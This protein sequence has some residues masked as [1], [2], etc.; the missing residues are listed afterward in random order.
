M[1]GIHVRRPSTDLSSFISSLPL[2]TT[3]EES[4]FPRIIHPE[5]HNRKGRVREKSAQTEEINASSCIERIEYH[6]KKNSTLYF[7]AVAQLLISQ[8]L[9]IKIGRRNLNV[10]K[11]FELPFSDIAF[12]STSL[13]IKFILFNT[14]SCH[15]AVSL[16]IWSV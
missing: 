8:I 1:V 11:H 15:F 12:I 10:L 16:S 7:C 2:Q 5:N 4:V 9:L 6:K 3:S 13:K 14:A